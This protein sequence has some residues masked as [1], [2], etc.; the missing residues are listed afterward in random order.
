MVKDQRD[1]RREYGATGLRRAAL[2]GDP[3]DQFERWFTEAVDAGIADATAMALATAGADG[4]PAVR[5]V[6]LKH[7][8]QNG[9]CWY[10]DYRSAKGRELAENPRASC[11]FHW[12]ELNRQVRLS[13]PVSRLDAA[14][15][16][17]YFDSRPGDSRFS[18]AASRQSAVVA[19]RQA[20]EERVAELRR[21]HP[22]GAV[23]RPE[24]WGGYRLQPESY[25]FWQGRTGRLHDR[26]RYTRSGTS[27]HIERLQP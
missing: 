6:L 8:D 11:L 4:Q 3:L 1:T 15:A 14:D 7:F 2:Q 27:W 26:F 5:I 25:E 16:T 10:T 20:L 23:P 12:R 22:D 13:G 17:A 21:Q 18:A 9:F 19:S 24:E